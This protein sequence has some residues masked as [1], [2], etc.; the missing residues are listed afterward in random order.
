MKRILTLSLSLALAMGLTVPAF[1][2]EP[3]FADMPADHWSAPYVQR[4]YEDGA[5]AGIYTEEGLTFAPDDPL[6]A[7]QFAAIVTQAFCWRELDRS[8]YEPWYAPYQKTAEQAGL[9]EGAGIGDWEAPM[10]RYQMAAMLFRLAQARKVPLPEEEA[11]AAAREKIADWDQV[12][13]GY[14][15]AVAASYALGLL[16]GID[17]AGT[18][19]GDQGLIRAQAAVVYAK[20]D[21]AVRA[22]DGPME[23]ALE[24]RERELARGGLSYEFHRYPGPKGTVYVAAQLGAPH[25]GQ[26]EMG[27]VDQAGQTLD[28]AALLPSY[29][30]YGANYLSPSE[31]VFSEDGALLTF[32]TPIREGKGGFGEPEE[33]KDWGPTRCTVDLVSGTMASMEPLEGQGQ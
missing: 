19:G 17:T 3:V 29:F 10:T 5:I 23:H 25:G 20:L 1:A 26:V 27:C 32:V 22:A 11:L 15:E 16:S 8:L 9:T 4:A 31:I 18:F 33:V 12:P 7:G 28:I 2:E 21:D 14:Q 24:A 6:T 13:E 30:M